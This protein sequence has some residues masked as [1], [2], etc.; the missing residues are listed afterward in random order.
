[1]HSDHAGHSLH[2]WLVSTSGGTVRSAADDLTQ[3]CSA[4]KGHLNHH[5]ITTLFDDDRAEP[6]MR[7][8]KSR[9]IWLVM[10]TTQ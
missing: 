6:G 10:T 7:R 9:S 2:Q 1:M 3:V 8:A 5:D 4:G